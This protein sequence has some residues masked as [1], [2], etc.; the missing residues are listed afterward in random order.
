MSDFELPPSSVTKPKKGSTPVKPSSATNADNE[1][2]T[3]EK[4]KPQWSPTELASIFD[5]IIFSGTYSETMDIR[6]KLKL[7]FRTRTAEEISTIT[8]TLDSTSAN[9]IST[10]NEKRSLMNLYYSLVTYQGKDLS[11]I[12]QEDREAFINRLPAPIVGVLVVSLAK[13]DSKVYAACAEGEE[14]F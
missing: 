5:E 1:T 6:G 2:V 14:N 12:R 11:S 7:R 9:L 8:D 10:V 4:I 3:Q 13:F